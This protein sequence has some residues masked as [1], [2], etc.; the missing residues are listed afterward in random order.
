M[1]T[2]RAVLS[3]IAHSPGKS[4]LTIF[5][6][7]IGVGVLIL[8]LSM[9][10]LFTTL[11]DEEMNGNE[12]IITLMNGE[13]NSEGEME[14]SRPPEF[15]ENITDVLRNEVSGVV[16]VSPLVSPRWREIQVGSSMYQARS[17]MG[18]SAEYLSMMHLELALGTFFTEEDENTGTRKAVITET[19]AE[20]LYGSSEKAIGST[21][22][23]PSFRRPDA[24]DNEAAPKAQVYTV[25]GVIKD[26][27]DMLRKAYGVGDIF[28]PYTTAFPMSLNNAFAKRMLM[29]T[30]VVKIEGGSI[31]RAEAQIR[32]VLTREYGDDLTLSVWE[33]TPSGETAWLEQTR[34]TVSMFN[35]VV[36]LLGF[37]LLVI[38]SI[39]ILSI[40]LVEVLN[41]SKEIAM[42]RAFGASRFTIV[43]EFFARSLLFSLF[44]VLIGIALSLIFADPLQI[45]LEPVLNGIGIGHVSGNTVTPL[46]IFLGS[47]S[48]LLVGGFFGVLPVFSA[49]KASI[50][51]AIRGV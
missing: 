35:L 14:E 42:E 1:K 7:G 28:I 2:I 34:K 33:G 18:V 30:Q 16:S 27:S 26:P 37:V 24:S 9:S 5:T 3:S 39:G 29:T 21:L 12:N 45:V 8:A 36:N 38:G 41:R 13:L 32:E 40:M 17:V 48:A 43:K 49:L 11:I 15:D 22:Q 19:T 51:D 44:S 50:S 23:P 25:V 31:K 20:L 10:S 46:A 4:V 47:I 6:V